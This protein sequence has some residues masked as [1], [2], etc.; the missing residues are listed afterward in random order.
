[1]QDAAT[2]CARCW[3]GCPAAATSV[4]KARMARLAQRLRIGR[5]PDVESAFLGRI[6]VVRSLD[7]PS[8]SARRYDHD[9]LLD[10]PPPHTYAAAATIA[11][12]ICPTN[13]RAFA[14]GHISLAGLGSDQPIMV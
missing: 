7:N 6:S 9:D 13:G 2:G 8:T 11:A 14:L 10:Q 4:A 1:V 12:V 5:F 3:D